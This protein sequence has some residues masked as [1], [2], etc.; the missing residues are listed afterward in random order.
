MNK[1]DVLEIIPTL[2]EIVR[3]RITK[4]FPHADRIT[5][6]LTRVQGDMRVLKGDCAQ[7]CASVRE[8]DGNGVSHGANL[9]KL[10]FDS[11]WSNPSFDP[12][13]R[14]NTILDKSIAEYRKWVKMFGY[15]TTAQMQYRNDGWVSPKELK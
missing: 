8:K 14:I 6:Q 9:L 5:V 11:E 3:E 15:C 1:E 4:E 12:V 2:K 13:E 7:L 10:Y